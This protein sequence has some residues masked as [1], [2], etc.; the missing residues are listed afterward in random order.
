[1]ILK[2]ILGNIKLILTALLLLSLFLWNGERKKRISKE[3]ELK[4]TEKMLASKEIE[5]ATTKDFNN[6]LQKAKTR[7]EVYYTVREDSISKFYK[8]RVSYAHRKLS[9]AE[10]KLNEALREAPDTVLIEE[11]GQAPKT[12]SDGFKKDNLTLRYD[13]FYQGEIFDI[14]FDWEIKEKVVEN[15][16]IIYEDRPVYVPTEKS[17]GYASYSYGGFYHDFQVGYVSKKGIGINGGGIYL[18]NKVSPKIGV[19]IRF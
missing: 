11:T 16:H 12:L 19:T 10:K 2:K 6:K 7:R 13:I 9:D 15:N 4:V 8:H 5:L 3:S 1:M 17:F 18:D 14:D